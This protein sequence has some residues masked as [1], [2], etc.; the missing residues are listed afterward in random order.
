MKYLEGRVDIF[1]CHSINVNFLRPSKLQK[2]C[3][4]SHTWL[5]K[6]SYNDSIWNAE[7]LWFSNLLKDFWSISRVWFSRSCG[8]ECPFLSSQVMLMVQGPHWESLQ[9]AE[10]WAEGEIDLKSSICLEVKLELE[11][12]YYMAVLRKMNG[13]I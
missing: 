4:E 2:E 7:G 12:K 1:T 9:K 11:L 5:L 13:G 6:R 3:I 8:H 10:N